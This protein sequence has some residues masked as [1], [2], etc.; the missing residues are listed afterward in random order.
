MQHVILINVTGQ[1]RRGLTAKLTTILA[2]AGMEVLDM[3]QSVIHDYLTLGILVR[4]APEQNDAIN[5]LKSLFVAEG[6]SVE[7]EVVTDLEYADWV[8]R[9][10]QTRSILTIL[11]RK[12]TAVQLSR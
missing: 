8:S 2:Q 4:S 9:Q 7:A 1:D 3:G 10:G 12:I 6:L 5:D 11:G